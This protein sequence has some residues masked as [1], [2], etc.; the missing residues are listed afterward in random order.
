VTISTRLWLSAAVSLVALVAFCAA[1]VAELGVAQTADA[2]RVNARETIGSANGVLS[3]LKD[4]EGGSRGFALT[5]EAGYLEAFAAARKALPQTLRGL[6]ELTI[7][8]GRQTRDEVFRLERIV[9][10]TNADVDQI[11]T[12]RRRA[13][14]PADVPLGALDR[15]KRDMDSARTIVARIRT[16]AVNRLSEI[17]AKLELTRRILL[18]IA[19][20]GAAFVAF[21]VVMA[22][23]LSLRA[24]SARLTRLQRALNETGRIG[25][26]QQLIDTDEA[27]FAGV[28]SAF[29]DMAIRLSSEEV[30]RD[31]AERNM[32]VLN[33]SL[34]AKA[35][36]LESYSST[37]NIVRRMSDRLPSCT[38]E[39]EF[40]AVIR[41]FAPE[42]TSGRAGTLYLLNNSRN[43][44]HAGGSWKNPTS[45]LDEF[46]PE[47]CWGLRR[48][49]EHVS[50]L[51]QV[52]VTCPHIVQNGKTHWCM[53]LIAQSETVGLLYLE[54]SAEQTAAAKSQ[55]EDVTYM[56]R[57]TVALGL[58]NLRLREKLRSQ[59]VR[60]PLTA[61]FNRRYLDES[62]EIEFARS[63]RSEQPIAAIMM[64]IDHF[65][66]FNDTF[67]H[68]AGDVVLKEIAGVL[69]RSTR[70]GDIA[71]RFG[72][73]EF[74]LLLPGADEQ[75]AITR[76]ETMR[77]AIAALDLRFGDQTLG[78]VT[79][80]FGVAV[81]PM[82]GDT[83]ESLLHAAD[84]ALYAAKA[85]GRD[86]V[87]A[88]A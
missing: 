42:L 77:R 44:L 30:R 6:N 57:E 31:E 27:D 78:K 29:N 58:V 34:T 54:G 9:A 35:S 39:E 49:Q 75:R 43:L 8:D 13:K 80:S 64:D 16:R 36:E 50:G 66:V 82:D 52:E 25:G 7:A 79:A 10:R 73:E 47:E 86:R 56:L 38:D 67:G 70:K 2:N 5:G 48:G 62:L 88:P 37:V 46:T 40:S 60:D 72:G 53:P 17:S 23:A 65:K 51:D 11:V 84:Q 69:G 63:V 26:G 81:F 61:L 19:F 85:A 24:F 20:G 32:Q 71:G 45:S 18:F 4:L 12:L 68:D 41:S 1:L 59:S 15:A 28:A 21:I 22:T 3:L 83:R 33:E 14:S 76:A 55:D 87:M 74:L